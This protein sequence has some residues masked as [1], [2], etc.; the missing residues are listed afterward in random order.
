MWQKG[1]RD[2]SRLC[3]PLLHFVTF[4]QNIDANKNLP[5]LVTERWIFWAVIGLGQELVQRFVENVIRNFVKPRANA[6]HT[7]RAK[8]AAAFRQ[9]RAATVSHLCG[10]ICGI[11]REC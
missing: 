2:S 6:R 5:P 10:W 8:V 9:F 11:A 1:A 4:A 3:A 7:W